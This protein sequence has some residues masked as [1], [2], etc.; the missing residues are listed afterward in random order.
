MLFRSEAF[1]AATH[2]SVNVLAA[3][4][5]EISDRFAARS[6]DRFAGVPVHE[7]AFGVPQID[8]SCATFECANE[9]QYAGGD[10]LIFVGRVEHFAQ[11]E[12]KS[13]LIFHGGRYREL[14]AD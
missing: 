6:G 2:Y 10:H 12:E 3:D 11:D 1:R 4:Q 5:Q 13:P 8:G 9:I 14:H 7:G